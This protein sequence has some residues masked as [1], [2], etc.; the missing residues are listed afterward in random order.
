MTALTAVQLLVAAA[1]QGEEHIDRTHHWL[2]PEGYEILW[3][4]IASVLIFT[5]VFWK[6]SPR[7]K[8][9]LAKRTARFQA[10]LDAAT[11]DE[12]EAIAE[13]ARIRQ[14]KGDI[15]S[16]RTRMLAEADER[17]TALLADGR[18]RL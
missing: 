12:G 16:E 13:P 6:G 8:K 7:V 1:E 14:A 11:Q 5:A 4:G 15:E 17:A 9:A 10:E 2:W 3:G 18:A